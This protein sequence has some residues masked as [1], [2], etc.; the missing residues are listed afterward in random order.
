MNDELAEY[1]AELAER[2]PDRPTPC[3]DSRKNAKQKCDSAPGSG[4]RSQYS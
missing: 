3:L 2:D 4:R 1:L